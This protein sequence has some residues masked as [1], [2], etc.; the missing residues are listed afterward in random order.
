MNLYSFFLK[1]LVP[2]KKLIFDSSIYTYGDLKSKIDLADLYLSKFKKKENILVITEDSYHLGILLLT[3]AKIGKTIIPLGKD[4]KEK[5]IIDQISY[6]SPDLIIYSPAFRKIVNKIK[7]K[8]SICTKNIFKNISNQKYKEKVNYSKKNFFNKNYIITFSSGTTSRPK[9]ILF[10]QKIKYLRYKHIKKLYSVRKT[11]VILTSSPLDHSLGQRLFFLAVLTGCSLV[12]LNSYNLQI[13][14]RIIKQNK[15]SF[16]ILPSNYLKLLK[17]DLLNKK[18]KIRKVVS[19][20]SDISKN[21]K[22]ALKKKINFN[23]MYGA[24]EVGTITNLKQDSPLSKINSVGRV[25]QN[26][27]VKIFDKNYKNLSYNKVGEIGCKTNLAFKCYFRNKTLTKNSKINNFFLT[28]DIG[29]IDKD[30]Y[31]YFVSRKKDVIISSGINIYPV[32]IEKEINKN[33]NIKESAVIGI[34]DDFFGEIAFAVCVLKNKRKNFELSLRNF[35]SKRLAN[36]QQPIGY[37]FVET[38][39]RNPLGKILKINLREI[40]ERKKLDFSKKLRTLLN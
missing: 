15:V 30:K 34:K 36:F 12:Y 8:S 25:L 24:S 2:R 14:K 20:A 22:L 19:A 32:D 37:D 6:V 18:I 38:L 1:E 16:T 10:T 28:G 7:N 33:Q 17:S 27:K 26:T 5:Q 3:T 29:Y 23:E 21:D 39:P 13:W 35:L 31:L 11:D 4:L 40:Y 9:P